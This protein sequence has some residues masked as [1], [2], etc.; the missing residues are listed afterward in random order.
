MTAAFTSRPLPWTVRRCPMD[1]QGYAFVWFVEDAQKKLVL[2]VDADQRDPAKLSIGA[3]ES[4]ANMIVAAPVMLAALDG[5]ARGLT[6][7]QRERG[8]SFQTIAAEALRAAG[9]KP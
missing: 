9:V 7:G 6:N 2:R 5:I 8:E 3:A 4:L 1:R